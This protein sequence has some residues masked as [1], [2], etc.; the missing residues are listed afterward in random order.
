MHKENKPKIHLSVHKGTFTKN[1]RA[2]GGRGSGEIGQTR[3]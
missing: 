1:V 2:Q 3:T